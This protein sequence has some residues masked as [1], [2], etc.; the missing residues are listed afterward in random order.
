MDDWGDGIPDDDE[1]AITYTPQADLEFNKEVSPQI[2]I[3]GKDSMVTFTLR[4]SN[5]GPGGA[6][7][8]EVKDV[9]PSGLTY[10]SSDSS[11]GEYDP[12]TGI[13][14]VGNLVE[15]AQATLKI[16]A[17]V[18]PHGDHLNVAE[19]VNVD[20]MDPDSTPNNGD[21]N[22][23]DYSQAYAL[24]LTP[25]PC[26]PYFY[27]VLSKELYRLDPPA[28]SDV[29]VGI[30]RE[31][32]NAIGWDARTN[33]IYGIG[34]FP[35]TRWYGHLLVVDASGIARDLGIPIG[36]S[37][38]PLND[39]GEYFIAADMDQVGNLYVRYG[40][41]GRDLIKIDVDSLT[42]EILQFTGSSGKVGDI[43]YID[44]TN[45][46]WGAHDSKL[47]KWDLSTRQ[48]SS[49]EVSGLP[50]GVYGAAFT[51][52]HDN[53]YV[54]NNNLG[55]Y[56][57]NNYTTSSPS[58][59]KVLERPPTQRND[60]ASCPHAPV[61]F[62]ADLKLSKSVDP[63]SAGPGD[64]VTFTITV[65]NKGPNDATGVEVTDQLPSGYTY[66]SS[67]PSQGTYDPAT[68]VWDVGDLANGDSA[69]LTITATVNASG[70]YTNT[71][72]VTALDQTDPDSTPNNGDP[73]EDDYG[74]ASVR[75]VAPLLVEKEVEPEVARVGDV[76][77][78]TVRI[79]NP[80]GVEAR[81]DLEDEF[82]VGLV[83]EGMIEG[84][85]PTVEGHTLRWEGLRIEPNGE[86]V[87]RYRMRVGPGAGETLDN[88]AVVR[89][90][91]PP[92][93]EARARA[94]LRI[95]ERMLNRRP[96][97]LLG[98]VYVDLDEDGAFD[99][100]LDVPLPG[101]RVVLANGRQ[102]VTD[103]EGRY[104][105]RDLEAGVWEVM[106]DPAGIPVRPEEQAGKL[107]GGNYRYRVRVMGA[108][109]LD[110]PLG[111]P[112]GLARAYRVVRLRYGP[113]MLEKRLVPFGEG[114]YRV[115]LVLRSEY[116]VRGVVVEDPLPGGGVRR[117][118]VG[119]LAGE[120]T[121]TY[122]LEGPAELTD[123]VVRWRFE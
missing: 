41:T 70:D 24:Y 2:V 68:G 36:P 80:V 100:G 44:H 66:V 34:P 122:E 116:E 121:L 111:A 106:F 93:H 7:N 118:E 72:E 117:F 94:R 74:E 91:G 77:T 23:D 21:P 45:A 22:E 120:E 78:Y 115:V 33:L 87:L 26:E 61:P 20:R 85:E 108:T 64:Q 82:D 38:V 39:L 63:T 40:L 47:Y 56:K 112:E 92:S 98:R 76:V 31:E 27:Q 46:F 15:G 81:F 83:Y 99:R 104:A 86:L 13:W 28:K 42:Y 8:I 75:V 54:V 32:Y 3:D 25:F 19:I 17:R 1:A 123:P 89:T 69:T 73:N 14:T 101:V 88:V 84:P 110:L 51:D 60:G 95:E 4:V 109:V 62:K 107:D 55:I 58:A 97:V 79:R 102:T 53:L 71:A 50:D 105:I 49:V 10:I 59:V 113:V 43:V 35:W 5:L 65:E 103:G 57:I 16:V 6:R 11:Q 29:L 119:E 114:R 12:L 48:I 90:E 96:N 18:E 67:T 30:S 9:L 37:G 52:D